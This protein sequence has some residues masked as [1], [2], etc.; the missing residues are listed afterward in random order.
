MCDQ[1]ADTVAETFF[2][3]WV[4]R[5]GVP[6]KITTDQGRQFESDLFSS[7][8]RF[9]GAHKTR[10]TAYHPQSN[11]M[12][13]RFHRQLKAAVMSHA[14]TRWSEVLPTVLLG[15]RA[16]L[17]EDI[18][19]SS[20]ELVF[21]APLRLPGE[22]LRPER[23]KLQHSQFLQLLR[24]LMDSLR[25]TP[26]SH[27]AHGKVF[28]LL[29]LASVI[30]CGK[31]DAGYPKYP[32]KPYKFGYNT[33]D[34]YGNTQNRYE[35]SDP[36]DGSVKGSYGYWN[37]DGVYRTVY[38]VA[39]NGG[40]RAK[41]KTN[42]PGTANQNPAG[43]QITAYDPPPA[44][45]S[46]PKYPKPAYPEPPKYQ[47]KPYSPPAYSESPKYYPPAKYPASYYPQSYSYF[48]LYPPSYPKYPSYPQPK[49]PSYPQPKYP[50]YPQYK[51]PSYPQPKYPSYPQPK[52]PSYPQPKYPSYPQPKYPSY[53]APQ[54]P[55]PAYPPKPAYPAPSYAPYKSKYP[56][57]T[58]PPPQPKY[59]APPPKYPA[60]P[61]KYPEPSYPAPQQKS[62]F[63]KYPAPPQYPIYTQ[64]PGYEYP[65]PPATA[66]PSPPEDVPTEEEIPVGGEDEGSAEEEG[67]STEGP[68]DAATEAPPSPESEGQAI[69][70]Q[71]QIVGRQGIRRPRFGK[72]LRAPLNNP[73][74]TPAPTS[75]PEALE[76]L[77]ST[78][79]PDA[80]WDRRT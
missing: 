76:L 12:V 46:H 77:R 15:I 74:T 8:S 80:I 34:G 51:Y 65:I 52:Y 9:L 29:C 68:S 56:A 38:Y 79:I 73:R 20:A 59:P 26:A 2:N 17:K 23:T 25:P 54:Y 69:E 63:T 36:Y 49:Y 10:T 61:P 37:A 1:T 39:D 35:S 14:T 66:P 4:T 45:Y 18:K 40:F 55:P 30:T 72:R 21:G 31:A 28:L 41:V 60:P 5:Y 53:P 11:R 33:D 67:P 48:N 62:Y 13:E 32:K 44:K 22:F 3:E 75:S 70:R 71:R 42:E 58:Y 6:E 78:T 7:L 16:A 19:T 50:S 64:S 24:Q 57:P 43:V 27:H 47:P